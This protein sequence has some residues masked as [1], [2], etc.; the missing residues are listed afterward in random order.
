MIVKNRRELST[1]ELRSQALDIIEAGIT[2]VLPP[3]IM[4][5]A[6]KH[7][8]AH[9]IL[10]VN[11]YAYHLSEGRVFVVG[12]GKASGLMAESLENI[13]SPESIS[14]G[15]VTCNCNS[16]HYKTSRIEIVE[17]GVVSRKWW[18]KESAYPTL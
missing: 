8:S 7:D 10:S 17:A 15:V 6:L 2:Q 4:R 18:K 3:V 9:R 16:N 1:S 13:L 5:F 11:D 12:G 14:A